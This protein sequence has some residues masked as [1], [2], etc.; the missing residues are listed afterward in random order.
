[1]RQTLGA[2]AAVLAMAN[3]HAEIHNPWANSKS[4]AVSE[5]PKK[6]RGGG[7]FKQNKRKQKRGRK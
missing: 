1:M 7:S 3:V 5:A 6:V 2:L 4:F